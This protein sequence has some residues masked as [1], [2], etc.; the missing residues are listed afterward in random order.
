M[1]TSPSGSLLCSPELRDPL[2]IAISFMP[3]PAPFRGCSHFTLGVW[4]QALYLEGALPCATGVSAKNDDA[5]GE[6]VAARQHVPVSLTR[7]YQSECLCSLTVKN[8]PN[9]KMIPESCVDTMP[10]LREVTFKDLPELAEAAGCWVRKC[11]ALECATFEGLPKLKSVGPSWL[12][13]NPAL[14][15]VVIDLPGLTEVA[16]CW[17]SDCTNLERIRLTA[18]ELP[19]LRSVK[20][21]WLEGCTSLT[22]A[23]FHLSELTRVG[24]YWM[25]SCTSLEKVAFECLPCV[26]SFGKCLQDCRKLKSIEVG[27]VNTEV[28]EVLPKS[29]LRKK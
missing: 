8:I 10:A 3:N 18:R 20:N 14:K 11:P 12:F 15:H 24:D 25:D 23:T 13:H 2:T 4:D 21:Y 9:L 1:S 27:E 6:E 17:L 28:K 29:K 7:L 16:S 19:N 22:S 5:D 26:E